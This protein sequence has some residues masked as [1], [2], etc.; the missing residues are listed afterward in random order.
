MH[1]TKA[2][3]GYTL[4]ELMIGMTLAAVL[5]LAVLSTYLFLGRNTTRLSYQH[6]LEVEART[7]LNTIALDVRNTKYITSA[8]ATG[9]SLLLVD[10]STVTYSYAATD[11]TRDPGTG[12]VSLTN[13]IKG[14]KVQVPVSMPACNFNYYTTNDGSPTYQATATIVPL[15][16]KQ[17]AVNFTLRAGTASTQGSLGTMTSFQIASG[18]LLFRNKQLPNGT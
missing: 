1:R 4:V 18:W 10:G 5:M 2:R 6:A 7:I 13:D 17:V 15:G 14:E 8:S 16:I 12:A 3:H 11:L 9:L